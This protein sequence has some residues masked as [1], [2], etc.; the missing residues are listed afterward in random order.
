MKRI[1][2]LALFILASILGPGNALGQGSDVRAKIPFD[3]IVGNTTLPA[4]SYEITPVFTDAIAISNSEASHAVLSMV[5]AD[6][7]QSRS[8]AVLVFQKHGSSYFLCEILGGPSG[9]LNVALPESKLEK[10]ARA[11]ELM[12]SNQSQ[13][14]IPASEGN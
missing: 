3:F 10:R 13:I 9:K 1:A 14:S 4:G 11:L 8:G 12:A 2:T 5:S 6:S 7:T